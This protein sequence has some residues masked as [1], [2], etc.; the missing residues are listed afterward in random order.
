M[1][2]TVSMLILGLSLLCC[3]TGCKSEAKRIEQ[4]KSVKLQQEL[5]ELLSGVEIS[6]FQLEASSAISRLA[7]YSSKLPE[8]TKFVEAARSSLSLAEELSE[9]FER[10]AL[11]ELATKALEGLMLCENASA[12]SYEKFDSFF[13]LDWVTPESASPSGIP[14]EADAI[15]SEARKAD[16]YRYWGEL[17]MTISFPHRTVVFKLMTDGPKDIRLSTFR[18]VAQ[19]FAEMKPVNNAKSDRPALAPSR[20]DASKRFQGMLHEALKEEPNKQNR[21]IMKTELL[22]L[23]ITTDMD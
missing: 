13:S 3:F 15:H 23:G 11:G 5:S 10:R 21:Q 1:N 14:S 20:E 19:S 8:N 17:L 4:E 9:P 22:K 18:L 16:L 2:K 6:K 7:G 12:E